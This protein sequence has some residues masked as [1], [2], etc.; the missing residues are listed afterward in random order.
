MI[1]LVDSTTYETTIDSR[2]QLLKRD[3]ARIKGWHKR[4]RCGE[5]HAS[6]RTFSMGLLRLATLLSFNGLKVRY[7]TCDDLETML[8]D[9]SAEMPECIAFST[10]CGT[11]PRCDELRKRVKAASPSTRVL[12]GGAHVNV[13]E[14]LTRKRYPGFDDYIAAYELEAASRIAGEGLAR[15]P[16]GRYVDFSL[17]PHPM[18][19][20]AINTFVSSGCMFNCRYCQD[21]RAPHFCAHESGQIGELM[22]LLRPRTWV[23]FFDSNFGY[24]PEGALRACDAIR[25]TG[26]RF[27]LSCDMRAEFV[28]EPL[29]RAMES[30]GF[31][32]IRMGI[33]SPSS[34]VLARNNRSLEP[35]RVL[36]KARLVRETSDIYVSLYSVTCL[37]GTTEGTMRETEEL[38]YELL[39]ERAVDEVKTCMFVPYPSDEGFADGV[40]IVDD[41]WSHYDR[42]HYPVFRYEDIG[43]E[44]LWQHYL[45]A[46][47]RIN[48]GWL[49]G[50]GV[51]GIDSLPEGAFPEYFTKVYGIG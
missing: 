1:W 51:S 18:Q 31:R 45:R 12:I 35:G 17:L 27:L 23:H 34:A 24:T 48:D 19:E 50:L 29:I 2:L 25:S 11:V 33:E 6:T 3:Y 38:F 20:Y 49:D 4:N 28:T 10:V 21:G 43:R 41:D 14:R 30:A 22:R 8:S 44:E 39:A 5:F 47:E 7:L 36:E 32:E 13:A 16:V 37:P 9:R 15:A 46:C 40:R 42:Q 26:H